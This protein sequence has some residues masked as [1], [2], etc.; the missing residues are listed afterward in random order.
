MNTRAIL[1]CV[2]AA[3]LALLGACA[4]QRLHRDGLEDMKAGRYEEGIAKLEQAAEA[5][6]SNLTIRMDLRTRRDLAVQRSWRRRTQRERPAGWTKH[7]PHTS[8]PCASTRR[9]AVQCTASTAFRRIAATPP[10]WRRP[11]RT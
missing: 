7:K 11:S 1:A 8:A 4:S 3:G 10:S 9:T 6:P 2:A 5:N